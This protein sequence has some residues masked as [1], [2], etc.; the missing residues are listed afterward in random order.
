MY[1]RD[2]GVVKFVLL[3]LMINSG[4][5]LAAKHNNEQVRP[6]TVLYKLVEGAEPNQVRGL[7][8]I[9]RGQ[10]LVSQ[11]VLDGSQIAIATFDHKGREKAIANILKNS[12]YVEFAEPDV[13]VVPTIS[14]NDTYFDNQWHHT[15]VNS[16]QA[17]EVTTGS[18][19]VLVGVCDTGFDVEH[20]DLK[21]NLRIDLAYNAEDDNTNIFDADGHGTGSAGTLGALG[22]NGIG[23]A[24]ANWNVDIIPVRIAISDENSSAYI[25]T[26]AKC[27]EYA[28]DNGARIV[29]LS[30]GGIQYATIDAAAKYLRARN[31]L[32]FMSAGNDG[33]EFA[34]YPD[35]ESFVGVAAT[36]QNDE[37]ASFSNWGTFVDI[38]APGVSIATTYPDNRYVYYS[39]TSFSSPLTAGIAALMVA[40]NPEITP[41]QIEQGLFSTVTDLGASG[42]DVV[43]GH[44]LVNALAAVNYASNLNSYSA[45]QS[46]ITIDNFKSEYNLDELIHFNGSTSSDADGTIQTYSWDF[47]NGETGEGSTFSYS[48]A[49]AGTYTVTLTVQ[50]D[51]GLSDSTTTE[52]VVVD[53]TVLVAPSGLIGDVT[54]PN[55]KLTWQDNSSNENGFLVERGVK[56]RGRINFEELEIVPAGETTFTDT[57]ASPGE[58]RYRVSAVNASGSA[59]SDTIVVSVTDTEPSPQPGTL[60]SPSNLSGTLSNNVVMLSWN[61]NSEGELGFIVERGR[62]E[63]GT[64]NFYEVFRTQDANYT[65]NISDLD[66]G[67]YGYRVKAY[68]DA[69]ESGYSNTMEFRKK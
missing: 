24:G 45:P 59:T 27:I 63:K 47:G 11:V 15:A 67:N 2:F 66:G 18:S 36:D 1:L 4:S 50:D 20:P 64:V 60:P 43:F 56:R 69:G 62:K 41:K 52:V 32:L 30:Y 42:D 5:A 48:Y 14:P 37:K 39:G 17:W 46:T 54:G 10:G 6:G 61:D 35:Y 55:V 9:L 8:A 38:T 57:V 19:S 13:A 53:S 29:N 33:Q 28:A 49:S 68:N 23:V 16:Q 58:Y 31:G 44:G 51:D 21:D 25:S 65:D 40:A 34:S 22:N 12:G 7:N 3:C 26:M